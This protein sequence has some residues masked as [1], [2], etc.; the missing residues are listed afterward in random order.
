[1]EQP[2]QGTIPL[3]GWFAD[4]VARLRE[5]MDGTPGGQSSDETDEVRPARPLTA[6]LVRIAPRLMAGLAAVLLLGAIALLGFRLLFSDRIYPAVV[7]GDVNVGGLTVDQA[8]ERLAG[9]ASELERSSVTFTYQGKSWSPT[10]S[11]LGATIQTDT[12]LAQAQDLG[13]E[14]D[15]V[16]RLKFTGNIIRGDQTVPLRTSLDLGM[17]NAW[18]DRV[19]ADLGQPAVDAGIVVQ[20]TTVS[21]TPEATGIVVD[22]EAARA[23]I[24]QTLQNLRPINAALPTVV[25]EPKLRQADLEAA[26]GEIQQM[27]SQPVPVQFE[28]RGWSVGPEIIAQY[29][30]VETSVKNGTPDVQAEIDTDKLT[31][32]LRETYT[33]EINRG[34][35]NAEVAWSDDAGLIALTPSVD[36]A[37]LKA[38]AFAQAVADSFLNG[39]DRV[40]VPVH[41]TKPQIDSNNL[42]AL[43]IETRIARG[44]S[45]YANGAPERD[46]NIEVG[47]QLLNGTLVPPGEDFSFNGAVGEITADKGFV[48]AGVILGERFDRDIGGGICQVSTTV[49]RAALLAGFPMPEWWPHTF[50]LSNYERDGW[51]PGYDA[52][53]YQGG[54]DPS[55]W[56]DFKFTNTTDGWLLVQSW[57]T[58]PNVIVDIYGPTVEWDVQFSNE[59]VSEPIK[60]NEDVEIVK[61][62]LPAGTIRQVEGPQ[63]GLETNFVRTVYDKN[64]QVIEERSYY[65]YFMGRGNVYEVSPDMQGESPGAG[66]H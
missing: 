60:D 35:V 27:L 50:R 62:D 45:N 18:F 14:D 40:E 63:E 11:E 58:Y 44:D 37:T 56:S 41:V 33:G 28:D 23:Q 24:L 16:S 17:L 10:L 1:M 3:R 12:S 36:G 26:R 30:T 34:P 25:A 4:T 61:N 52:A 48:E 22:R 21:F 19:D 7:V 9:R 55:Q 13:R 59:Y 39:H 20:G 6:R 42:A 53:I 65:T 49:Y 31:A 8:R 5:R 57:T 47:V 29:L 54:S 38:E 51:G 64:G 46:T 43:K 15:A 32:Y 2:R 66:G